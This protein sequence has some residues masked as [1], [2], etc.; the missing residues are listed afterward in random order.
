MKRDEC[1]AV[2]CVSVMH[3][4]LRDGFGVAM[5][6]FFGTRYQHGVFDEGLQHH[7]VV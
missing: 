6:D 1:M 7:R 2:N 4:M 5:S 3:K